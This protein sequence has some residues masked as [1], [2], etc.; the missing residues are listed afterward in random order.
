MMTE[1]EK[2]LHRV[3]LF[4]AQPGVSK[5]GLAVAAGLHKNA[6]RDADREEWNPT[7]DTLRKIEPHLPREEEFAM[8]EGDIPG[9]IGASSDNGGE[10]IGAAERADNGDE[11][12]LP[13]A[14]AAE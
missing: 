5:A 9:E 10:I 13:Q 2:L 3:R 4:L 6:L 11:W 1:T 14:E 7:A 12:P 8:T